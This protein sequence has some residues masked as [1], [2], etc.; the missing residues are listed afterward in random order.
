VAGGGN[1]EGLAQRAGREPE[2]GGAQQHGAECLPGPEPGESVVGCGAEDEQRRAVHVAVGV[3]VAGAEPARRLRV[4]VRSMPQQVAGRDP[5]LAGPATAPERKLGVV[6]GPSVLRGGG[7][8]QQRQQPGAGVVVGD[9]AQHR[10]LG[11]RLVDQPLQ[12]LGRY[13]P[14][15]ERAAVGA[16]LGDRGQQP[17][18]GLRRLPSGQLDAGEVV[19]LV[20]VGQAVH[21]GA[22]AR[23]GQPDPQMVQSRAAAHD[24]VAAVRVRGGQPAM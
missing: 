13:R 17:D 12:E 9:G 22:A 1:L 19:C 6:P 24:E 10:A 15:A 20:R 11:C 18:G 23:R 3:E 16:P 21:H 2:V 14:A 8:G 7:L 5:V 4:G